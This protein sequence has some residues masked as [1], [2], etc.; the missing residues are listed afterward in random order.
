[1]KVPLVRIFVVDDDATLLYTMSSILRTAGYTV[2]A[3]E[4]PQALLARLSTHDRG[5]LV[6]DLKMPGY[7]GLELQLSLIHI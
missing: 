4:Q 7:S 2:E 5:A 3:F 6:L 1:M